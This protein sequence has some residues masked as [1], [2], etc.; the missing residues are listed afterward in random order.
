[1]NPQSRLRG[2]RRELWIAIYEISVYHPS[3]VCPQLSTMTDQS[4]GPTSPLLLESAVGS[5]DPQLSTTTDQSPGP[6]SPLPFA[7]P[8]T[9]DGIVIPAPP[10][11]TPFAMV[12]LTLRVKAPG[13]L[14]SIL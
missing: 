10:L 5:V 1:M 12:T 3:S 9:K 7:S 2:T 13:A 11:M 4:P 8:L 14:I 6:M